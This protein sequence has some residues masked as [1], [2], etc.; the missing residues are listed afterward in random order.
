MFYSTFWTLFDVFLLPFLLFIIYHHFSPSLPNTLLFS[1]SIFI[2]FH[3]SSSFNFP[4]A[5]QSLLFHSSYFFFCSSFCFPFLTTLPHHSSLPGYP[6]H[7]IQ[8]TLLSF[9]SRPSHFLSFFEFLPLLS[10]VTTHASTSAYSHPSSTSHQLFFRFYF[11]LLLRQFPFLFTF[12]PSAAFPLYPVFFLSIFLPLY[13]TLFHFSYSIINSFTSCF[14]IL[15]PSSFPLS[16]PAFS[17]ILLHPSFFLF[18]SLR[19]SFTSLPSFFVLLHTFFFFKLPSS[20]FLF[21]TSSPFFFPLPTLHSLFSTLT[22]SFSFS[23]DFLLPLLFL[24]LR[25]TNTILTEPQLLGEI[26]LSG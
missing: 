11:Y 17:F 3:P 6:L 12:P 9:I 25:A 8:P 4:R 19:L 21:F 18:S 16:F 1:A 22:S 10:C 23:P 13:L 2:W 5:L 15:H 26:S 7:F 24:C 20:S 14:I